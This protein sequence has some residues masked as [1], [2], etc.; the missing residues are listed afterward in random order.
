M[1]EV[2]IKVQVFPHVPAKQVSNFAGYNETV[3]RVVATADCGEVVYSSGEYI[4]DQAVEKLEGFTR[5]QVI[6]ATKREVL[7]ELTVNLVANGV[8]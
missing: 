2:I 8:L 4:V 3:T 7:R 1:S 6:A 5:E